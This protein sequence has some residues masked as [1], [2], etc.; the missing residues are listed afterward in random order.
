MTDRGAGAT[1]RVQAELDRTTALADCG[2][3]SGERAWSEEDRSTAQANRGAL[4]SERV[5]SSVDLLT[6]A[7]V[8]GVGLVDLGREITR[9]ALGYASRRHGETL[10]DTWQRADE[11]M[12]RIKRSRRAHL[13]TTVR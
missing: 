8:R 12:Y 10:H 2:Q 9:V 11:A 13:L 5:H 3:G 6:G 7:H 1:E 4:A